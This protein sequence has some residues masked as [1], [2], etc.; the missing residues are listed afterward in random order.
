MEKE[1]NIMFNSIC[2]ILMYNAPM[3]LLGLKCITTL[4]NLGIASIVFYE[5][6]KVFRSIEKQLMRKKAEF[7]AAQYLNYF[8]SIGVQGPECL[9]S[10][11][12]S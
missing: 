7:R 8:I 3:D 5:T 4:I 9:R 12:T 6:M 11:K 2:I 10:F 1:I